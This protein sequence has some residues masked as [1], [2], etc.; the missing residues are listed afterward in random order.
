MLNDSLVDSTFKYYCVIFF[1]FPRFGH[2]SFTEVILT[3]PFQRALHFLQFE[4]IH[5]HKNKVPERYSLT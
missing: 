2:Y 3:S 4:S 5:C 1:H